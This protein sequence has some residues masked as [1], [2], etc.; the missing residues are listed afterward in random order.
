MKILVPKDTNSTKQNIAV[1]YLPRLRS[2]LF[3]GKDKAGEDEHG[4]GDHQQDD[5]KLLP[6]LVQRVEKTLKT[7]KVSDHLENTED[8]HYS[9][10]RRN[11]KEYTGFFYWPFL[12]FQTKNENNFL[13]TVAGKSGRMKFSIQFC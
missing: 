10:L 5:A 6:R 4:D 3:K 13:P 7:D 2:S 9:D 11:E 12:I 1:E 8:S